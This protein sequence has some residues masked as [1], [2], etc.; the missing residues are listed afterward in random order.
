MLVAMPAAAHAE[1]LTFMLTNTSSMAVKAFFTSPVEVE[2]WEEDVFGDGVLPSGNQVSINIAD[3]RDVCV[4]DMRFVMEND[5]EVVEKGID[6]CQLGE[7][8][9]SD[10]E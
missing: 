8:T 6:L 5:T 2:Q 10:A 7:Y 4:Y 1:D 9:L 3:G